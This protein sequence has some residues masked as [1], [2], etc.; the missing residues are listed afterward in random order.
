M[1]RCGMVLSFSRS[2]NAYGR[3]LRCCSSDSERFAAIVLPAF[4]S[5]IGEAVYK[6]YEAQLSPSTQ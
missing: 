2:P 6:N 1:S 4:K 3:F 5:G